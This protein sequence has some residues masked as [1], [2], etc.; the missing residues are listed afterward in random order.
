VSTAQIAREPRQG[1]HG[2][3]R[4]FRYRLPHPGEGEPLPEADDFMVSVTSRGHGA[5]YRVLRVVLSRDVVEPWCNGG[6]DNDDGIPEGMTCRVL[7]FSI[8]CVRVSADERPED[9]MTWTMVSDKR[10]HRHGV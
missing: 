8:G 5:V 7:H 10:T 6:N 3:H 9:A 4:L 1:H 2:A